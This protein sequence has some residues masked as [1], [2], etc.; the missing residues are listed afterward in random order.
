MV[1]RHVQRANPVSSPMSRASLTASPALWAVFRHKSLGL[2]LKHVNL[3]PLGHTLTN[4]DNVYAS[5]VLVERSGEYLAVRL[6]QPAWRGSMVHKLERQTVNPAPAVPLVSVQPL[7]A[8]RVHLGT[9][10]QLLPLGSARPVPLVST[11]ISLADP[12]AI[13]VLLVRRISSPVRH[14]AE[15]AILARSQTPRGSSI[16][17]FARL[18]GTPRSSLTW[19]P[20]P[21]RFA[22]VVPLRPR[23]A[24]TTVKAVLLVVS[25]TTL[26]HPPV[27]TA[28]L[29]R[30]AGV[31]V[32]LSAARARADPFPAA[33]PLLV[34]H[35]QS[36]RSKEGLD[37]PP[38]RNV[39]PVALR[40]VSVPLPAARAHSASTLRQQANLVVC[41]VPLAPTLI[42]LLLSHARVVQRACSL[43]LQV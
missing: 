4:S 9:S 43:A 5:S 19:V 15:H 1:K 30:S 17:S 35:V 14:H 27:P 3:A 23:L 16:A 20:P 39:Q 36:A 6:A 24:K 10:P 28:C 33:G 29:A 25:G 41:S 12:Y 38:V 26:Q 32:A 40:V 42:R 21:V 13:P 22:S 8:R 37:F 2:D 11:S 34:R 18:V 31:L 7:L